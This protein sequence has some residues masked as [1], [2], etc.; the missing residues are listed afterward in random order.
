MQCDSVDPC[1]QARFAVKVIHPAEHFQKH[2]L[3]GVGGISPVI[4]DAVDQAEN[5]LVKFSN[6]PGV[7]IF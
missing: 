5:R 4:Q 1:L 2:F 6:Q 3:R 7:R